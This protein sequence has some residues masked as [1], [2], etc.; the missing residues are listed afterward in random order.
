[1]SR[2]QNCL[3]HK[4]SQFYRHFSM[5]TTFSL[6][7]D[8]SEATASNHIICLQWRWQNLNDSFDSFSFNINSQN[9]FNNCYSSFVRVYFEYFLFFYGCNKTS[10]IFVDHHHY[11]YS[12]L[13][14]M[15]RSATLRYAMLCVA[16]LDAPE[17]FIYSLKVYYLFEKCAFLSDFQFLF[18]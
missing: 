4:K 15:H 2:R 18:L 3:L 13:S 17:N 16:L 1:M 10:I 11:Y 8:K 6:T 7:F 9:A 5:E 12:S 14:K